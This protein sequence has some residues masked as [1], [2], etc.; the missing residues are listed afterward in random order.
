MNKKLIGMI[1]GFLFI[2]SITLPS[3]RAPPPPP[4]FPPQ[5]EIVDIDP[6]PAL[7]GE[8]VDFEGKGYDP[9]NGTKYFYWDFD[10]DGV[11]PEWEVANQPLGGNGWQYHYSSWTYSTTGTFDVCLGVSDEADQWDY[12]YSSVTVYVNYP[13]ADF[14]Y[15]PEN[16]STQELIRFNDESIQGSFMIISWHWDFGDGDTSI[17]QNPSHQFI[18]DGE[19]Y[20]VL[21]ITDDYGLTDEIS[22]IITVNNVPPTPYIDSINPNPADEGTT[23]TFIGHGEDPD[24]EVTTYAWESDI[25][26]QLYTGNNPSFSSDS[27]SLGTHTISLIVRDDDFDWSE[28]VNE[29]LIIRE[30]EENNPPNTP[31]ITGSNSGKAGEEYN[32]TFSSVD[33]DGDAV[34]FYIE[35]GNGN[36][37]T[38]FLGSGEDLTISHTWNEKD[39]Y[40]IRAKAKDINGAE[41]D[42]ATLEVSM[43]KNKII[44]PFERFM[45]NHPNMFPLL[46]HLM[47]LLPVNPLFFFSHLAGKNCA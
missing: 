45:E 15:L 37:W 39:D 23:V 42:W 9:E 14:S 41:S 1:I 6:N 17:E 12:D 7:V 24:G 46:R 16:P 40:T 34:Q 21:N 2:L 3:I 26:G 20:V 13:N 38:E 5:A 19:Y 30:P 18:E 8:T 27:L 11:T 36:E 44:N 25:D 22:K 47:R 29:T 35:W 32:Y 28:P 4:N 31:E 10:Y 43:P 33:P